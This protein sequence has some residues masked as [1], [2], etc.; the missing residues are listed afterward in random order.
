MKRTL[1]ALVILA[2]GATSAHAASPSLTGV[3][4]LGGQRGTEIEVSLTGARLADAKEVMFYEPGVTMTKVQ[5]VNDGLVKVTLK[6]APDARLGLRDLRL[7]TATGLSELRT[8]SVG[9]LKDIPEAEPN[10]DFDK[11]QAITMNVTVN[12]VADNEDVDYFALTAKR[13]SGSRLRL[14]E[15]G[16]A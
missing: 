1:N 4:P 8:F 13:V 9:A 6:I 5:A 11:P 14:R 12:G 15:S 7:R 2:L 16:W 3:R 10:N